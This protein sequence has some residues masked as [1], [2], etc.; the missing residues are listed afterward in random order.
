MSR[1][2]IL[3]IL[4]IF[5]GLLLPLLVA[6]V[7]LRF[8]PVRT[9]LETLPVDDHNPL[10]RFTPNR[11][12]TYSKGWNF[13]LVNK[14]RTNNYGFVNDQDYD[15]SAHTPL[16]AVIGDSYVEALMVP[17]A[18]TMHGRLAR[19]VD[20][21][22][23]VYSFGVS[24]A[25]LSQYLGEASF[26]RSTFHPSG[27]V[28]VIIGN[29][30]DESLQGKAGPGSYYFRH[31]SNRL[32][33]DRDNY[34]PSL[35]RRLIRKSA[36]IRYLV[37]NLTGG[38]A[39]MKRLLRGERTVEPQYVGNTEASFTP[40]RLQESRQVVEAFLASLPASS[41]VDPA[42]TVLVVDA[43]R[44]AMYNAGDLKAATGSYFDV[45]RRYFMERATAGGFE[46]VDMEPR[47]MREY[48]LDSSR[49][50]FTADHHWNGHGHE[51]AAK[52][53]ASSKAFQ[54][55]FPA[56]CP[57]LATEGARASRP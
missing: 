53:V 23:R 4:S 5:I 35:G 50:E 14:G 55:L 2:K 39:K 15:S 20:K 54:Q 51:E 22:R 47:F 38:V 49:F 28:I 33:L 12:F 16:L 11:D 19:C 6:E 24:G 1:T 32:V 26:A 7:A 41:G 9:G 48:A 52:A 31:E 25:P 57:D 27:I 18:E 44:P 36:V 3:A 43:M 56:A 10:L 21:G 42:H 29:D 17:F 45:M 34:A 8:L 13:K 40:E 37:L 30:F 46:V